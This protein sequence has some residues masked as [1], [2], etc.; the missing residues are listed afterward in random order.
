MDSLED[1]L[2]HLRHSAAHLL[3]AAVLELYPDAKP[4]IGPSTDHGFYYD[5]DFSKP[6]SESDLT[7]IE[8]KMKSLVSSWDSFEKSEPSVQE[9]LDHYASNPYKQELI[10][11]LDQKGEKIFFYQAGDFLDLCRGGHV[12]SPKQSL[13][14]FKLLSIAG[15]YWRGDEKNKML[16]RI[17]GT[18]FFS[19]EDLDSYVKLRQEAQ[20][21]DHK[22]LGPKLDLFTFSEKVGSGL[23]LWTP[24]GALLR[25]L[26]DDFVWRLRK[27]HGYQRVEI[28]HITKKDL[29]EISGHWDKFSQELLKIQTR[30]G[31]LF[32]VKPMNCPFH[33][34][35]FDRKPHSY[36]EMPQ[37]YANTTMVYRDEQSGEL[38]GLSRVR[39]ITQDD[40]HVFCR[41]NQAKEEMSKIWDIVD[42]FYKPAGF[43]MWVRL[44]LSDP[45]TPDKYLGAADD[46][47]F[48][49]QQLRELAQERGVAVAEEMGEAAFYAPKL[50]FMAK[51][52]LDREW[53]VATIQLDVL[54]P[55]RFGLYCINEQSEKEDIFMIHA[56]IM[57]SIERYLSILIEHYA[58]AFPLWLSPVQA[59]ILPIS[60]R[61]LEYARDVESRLGQ[62]GLR[63][64]L[65]DRAERLQAK[66]RNAQLEKVPLMLVIG[67]K[68]V[69]DKTV[70]VRRREGG[71]QETLEVDKFINQTLK[72]VNEVLS[73]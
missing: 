5:F 3:A 7:K 40:A 57:G 52:S 64:E 67:Q 9:A 10:K 25:H 11:E 15:A 55:G 56:A 66:I 31:H 47:Q 29:F 63:V 59:K 62:A 16:T 22:V 43:E 6:P 1:Q 70:T 61:F 14:H 36:R 51:D 28:P 69:N 46:W 60:D 13:K 73:T 32:A 42:D 41:K 8:D 48:A 38:S 26:L 2:H 68:E 50:D 54:M 12:E 35:I 53:Q 37:R 65:D 33:A 23:P 72:K 18:A 39:A 45:S 19:Q 34:Q 30:E 49:E 20:A 17:Y 27:K 71:K 21:R 44:S 24:K 4:T 58:G